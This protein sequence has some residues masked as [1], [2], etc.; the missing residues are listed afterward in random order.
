MISTG[1][2][3][4]DKV[5]DALAS[6]ESVASVLAAFGPAIASAVADV[7]RGLAGL[8]ISV[9]L[10]AI[11][12]FFLLRDG[13]A[14]F[15]AA[16]RQLV[17]WRRD[18]LEAAA[19]RATTV[20]GNYMIGTGAISAV[21][22]AQP[23]PDHGDPRPAAGVAAGGPVIPRRVHPVYRVAPDDRSRV[24]GHRR[25]RVPAGHPDHADLHARLQ[26]RPGQHRGA[27][28]CTDEP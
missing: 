8:G 4:A 24:P 10:G 3:G 1:K 23:V 12:T 13:A 21:G 27:R 18:E 15:E 2:V 6:G 26:H 14:G 25:G 17:P 7:V 28:S 20:L 11:L 19:R 16:T 5:D 22:A 9:V